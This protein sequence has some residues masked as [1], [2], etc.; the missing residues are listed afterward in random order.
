V[1]VRSAVRGA[2]NSSPELTGLGLPA[3]NVFQ[4]HTVDVESLPV[5]PFLVLRWQP[6]QVGA[7]RLSPGV[8]H[9]LDVVVNDVPGDY[10]RFINPALAAMRLEGGIFDSLVGATIDGCRFAAAEWLE[11]GPDFDDEVFNTFYRVGSYRL[12][13]RPA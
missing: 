1:T 12:T 3:D 11:D 4:Q 7:H 8:Q 9:L 5:A 13:T 2:L 6:T 10:D